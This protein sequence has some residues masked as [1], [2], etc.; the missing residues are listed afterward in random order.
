MGG[1]GR[2]RSQHTHWLRLLFS[3]AVDCRT[4]GV[5]VSPPP[6][7]AFLGFFLKWRRAPCLGGGRLWLRVVYTVVLLPN[8]TE[9]ESRFRHDHVVRDV[10]FSEL[11]LFWKFFPPLGGAANSCSSSNNFLFFRFLLFVWGFKLLYL[12]IVS[13]PSNDLPRFEIRTTRYLL[14]CHVNWECQLINN[15]V[16]VDHLGR[17]KTSVR[18]WR[19]LRQKSGG[20]KQKTKKWSM[21]NMGNGR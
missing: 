9:K 19:S 14:H 21:S 1:V 2:G 10:P 16:K 13:W 12:I 8:Y 15:D 11:V 3:M 6:P 4:F 17:H 18:K 5:Y 20:K 7:P